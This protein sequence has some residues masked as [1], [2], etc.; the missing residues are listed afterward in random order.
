MPETFTF[1]EVLEP[2]SF[3]FKDLQ[4][5]TPVGS[6]GMGDLKMVEREQDKGI[7]RDAL[8][9][10]KKRADF[11]SAFDADNLR[12]VEALETGVKAFSQ[13][14][15]GAIHGTRQAIGIE[16]PENPRPIVPPLPRTTP[17]L[18]RG[19]APHLIPKGAAEVAAGAQQAAAGL[20]DFMLDPDYIALGGVGAV[21]KA[22]Q[23]TAGAVFTADMASHLPEQAKNLSEAV[24]TGGTADI[25]REYLNT[26][27]TALGT[28]APVAHS[29]LPKAAETVA[30]KATDKPK[31]PSEKS[32]ED[33]YRENPE[34]RPSKEK[35]PG[36]V[37]IS[38][39][40]LERPKIDETKIQQIEEEAS[41]STQ[42][43][44][45]AQ[46]SSGLLD[47]GDA[48]IRQPEVPK[49]ELT[50]SVKPETVDPVF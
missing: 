27:L 32:V 25:T 1:E 37:E 42:I 35:L 5:V 4:E 33:F 26:A 12:A 2:E 23:G 19:M 40:E 16:D 24:K 10:E 50:E 9:Q 11:N 14:W 28:A 31:T 44:T 6:S 48:K 36:E 30:Q 46:R 22:I 21:P 17:E 20:G 15:K 39:F 38:E 49:A 13:P 45:E 41:I 3:S 43:P 47:T 29:L 34:K 7:R 18:I 8:L